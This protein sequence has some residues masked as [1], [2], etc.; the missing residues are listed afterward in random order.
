VRESGW[1]ANTE[2]LRQRRFRDW[3]AAED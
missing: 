2:D 1:H 3:L